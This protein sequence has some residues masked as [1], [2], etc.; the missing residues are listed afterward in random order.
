MAQ[1]APST[2]QRCLPDQGHGGHGSCCH[3][4]GPVPGLCRLLPR[5]SS[6][7][8]LMTNG[9]SFYSRNHLPLLLL[10]SYPQPDTSARSEGHAEPRSPRG[11]PTPGTLDATLVLTAACP[12]ASFPGLWAQG[13]PPLGGLRAVY[14]PPPSQDRVRRVSTDPCHAAR[15]C[16]LTGKKTT[17]SSHGRVAS[18][19]ELG[20]LPCE[21]AQEEAL[22][23]RPLQDPLHSAPAR[24]VGTRAPC[25]LNRDLALLLICSQDGGLA[26]HWMEPPSTR[27]GKLGPVNLGVAGV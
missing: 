23:F 6:A 18:A 8:P 26:A 1:T 13:V 9:G 5:F 21:A 24:V 25:P 2:S 17:K 11:S 27:S 19:C 10:P 3:L 12:R 7:P 16:S 15:P 22:A 20:L 4:K 14:G